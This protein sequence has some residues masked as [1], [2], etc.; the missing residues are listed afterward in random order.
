MIIFIAKN[1]LKTLQ[2]SY[3]ITITTVYQLYYNKA[4]YCVFFACLSKKIIFIKMPS[5]C[6]IL[7]HPRIENHLVRKPFLK[8][9]SICFPITPSKYEYSAFLCLSFT[10]SKNNFVIHTALQFELHSIK[11]QQITR[12][13]ASFLHPGITTSAAITS[14]CNR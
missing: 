14:T 11:Y 12:S 13:H 9:P 2:Q 1:I 8:L 4:K 5:K 7:Y 10:R 3:T 6:H